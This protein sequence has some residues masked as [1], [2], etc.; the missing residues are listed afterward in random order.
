[1]RSLSGASLALRRGAGPGVSRVDGRMRQGRRDSRRKRRSRPPTPPI[2]SRTTRRPSEF[3][4]QTIAAAPDTQRPTRR[5]FFLGNSYDN[6]Y[7]PSKK[8]D[9]ANDAML[10]KAVDNYQKAAE[11]L[12]ASPDPADKK[13][14]KLSL[15]YLVASYGP[16]KLNDPAKAEPVV[17]KHDSARARRADQLL[18]AREDLRGRRRL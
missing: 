1:M 15:E 7:K 9:A 14:G 10:T 16:D 13:L 18:R 11:K 5:Y 6:Q 3:Y 12:A 8:G 2:S 17:Q 4:E